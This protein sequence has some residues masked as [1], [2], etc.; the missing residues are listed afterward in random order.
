MVGCRFFSSASFMF[1]LLLSLPLL[2]SASQF[3]LPNGSIYQTT[4]LQSA[5]LAISCPPFWTSTYWNTSW[6][7]VRSP[8]L[9]SMASIQALDNLEIGSWA[10]GAPTRAASIIPF[11]P[12]ASANLKNA[13]EQASAARQ[14]YAA[15]SS[16]QASLSLDITRQKLS[17]CLASTLLIGS[18]PLCVIDITHDIFTSLISSLLGP[19]FDYPPKWDAAM[20]ASTSALSSA[21]IAADAAFADAQGQADNL[22]FA[23]G[24]DSIYAGSA[25]PAL[26]E[27]NAFVS[28]ASRYSRDS[29]LRLPEG[30]LSNRPALAY[31]RAYRVLS[32][33]QALCDAPADPL[34]FNDS[35]SPSAVFNDLASDGERTLIAQ[36]AYFRS[37]LSYA[38]MR[39]EA[40]RAAAESDAKVQADQAA[41]R[42][43]A[44]DAAGWS[45]SRPLPTRTV[46]AGLSFDEGAWTSFG[47][48]NSRLAAANDALALAQAEREAADSIYDKR[49]TQAF[50]STRSMALNLNS[51]AHSKSAY[52][53]ASD[54]LDDMSTSVQDVSRLAESATENLSMKVQA[55]AGANPQDLRAARS[56]LALAQASL[57]SAQTED[58]SHLGARYDYFQNALQ[59]AQSG[60]RS[61]AGGQSQNATNLSQMRL[62]LQDLKQRIGW[63]KGLGV[64]DA[65][66]FQA[67]YENFDTQL[68][69]ASPESG[70][71]D[72]IEERISAV[73]QRMND[74]LAEEEAQ[75]QSMDSITQAIL[76]YRPGALGVWRQEMGAYRN[77]SGGWSDEAFQNKAGLDGQLEASKTNLDAELASVLSDALCI[78][79]SWSAASALPLRANVRQDMG[80]TWS[81]FNPL[82]VGTD[83]L[84]PLPP[85]AGARLEVKCPL[86]V[87]RIGVSEM[88]DASPS[89]LSA[90]SDGGFIFLSLSGLSA[91]ESVQVSFS[92]LQQPFAFKPTTCRL[93]MGASSLSLQA[94]Y[95]LQSSYSPTTL[96]V[97]VPWAGLPAARA[98]LSGE[99]MALSGSPASGDSSSIA[100]SIPNPPAGQSDWSARIDSTGGHAL[101]RSSFSTAPLSAGSLQVSYVLSASGLPPCSSALVQVSEPSESIEGLSVKSSDGSSRASLQ[102]TP[103]PN[104]PVWSALVT[105]LPPSGSFQLVVS[106]RI[107]DPQQWVNLSLPVLS[108][109]ARVRSDSV[110]QG[111]VEQARA[112]YAAGDWAK[113][114][115]AL[116]QAQGQLEQSAQA[117]P[118]PTDWNDTLASARYTLSRLDELSSS[119]RASGQRPAWANDVVEWRRSLNASLGAAQSAGS[120]S[121][122]QVRALSSD[123]SPVLDKSL[124]AADSDYSSLLKNL[125]SLRPL[126]AQDALVRSRLIDVDSALVSARSNIHSEDGLGALSSLLD[127]HLAFAAYQ[128]ELG[129]A[130]QRQ[131]GQQAGR[132]R[133]L[134]IQLSQAQS[135]L[136]Q[137]VDSLTS[138]G[139]AGPSS[140]TPALS[141]SAA[142]NLQTSLQKADLSSMDFSA[143]PPDPVSAAKQLAAREAPLQAANQTLSSAISS[144]AKAQNDL[145]AGAEYRSRVANAYLAEIKSRPSLA[146]SPAAVQLSSDAAGLA[147]MMA[148]QKWPDAIVAGESLM[149]RAKKLLDS[150]TASGSG[151]EPP[152]L[153]IGLT[154]LLLVGIGL[155]LMRG[156]PPKGKPTPATMPKTLGRVTGA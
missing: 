118:T 150:D 85:G 148:R 11:S 41:T 45:A 60:L 18:S 48:Y 128:S 35:G 5:P 144:L 92:S 40:E 116:Q 146:S 28:D 44:L 152:Y 111:F 2:P 3:L 98:S 83:A 89:V 1:I 124:A 113:A 43:N 108:E 9:Y 4:S 80:G 135:Q 91:G 71:L 68:L 120:P 6:I 63:A 15:A 74:A 94:D 30:D 134:A 55:S 39:L 84:N 70:A 50:W 12:D 17:S 25:K 61:L 65:E 88:I 123:L 62:L 10:P 129:A 109:Q 106:Y 46:A 156:R 76:P 57:A 73:N 102:Q 142:R 69:S 143:L 131:A 154:A 21:S 33:V 117:Q 145:Q 96:E 125:N 155:I 32:R 67:A 101:A 75:Y 105:S 23:G 140:F 20:Q 79:A 127:A 99:G 7:V 153:L 16:N 64:P 149:A 14:A 87:P 27:W 110:A 139:S 126:A 59:S 122:A 132:S 81:S 22:S 49:Q 38:Y 77:P 51:S 37:S 133:E 26:D 104:N 121:P 24:A 97:L 103:L 31:A 47:T 8:R 138:L 147:D 54:L 82:P 58:S 136:G 112:A 53:I 130:L 114:V 13:R 19:L 34:P 66:D 36:A 151:G 119:L 115:Y 141:L 86:A 56:A 93:A 137:Y 52:R 95:R 90:S 78:H 72:L 42:M 107:S 100:F 29:S